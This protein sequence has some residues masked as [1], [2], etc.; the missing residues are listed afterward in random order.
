MKSHEYHIRLAELTTPLGSLLLTMVLFAVLMRLGVVLSLLPAPW[1]AFDVEH[2]ILTHQALASGKTSDA[3][4]VLIGDSSCLM[5]AA[6][7]TLEKEFAGKHHAIN[8]G[9]FMYVGLNGYTALLSRYTSAN[10]GRLQAVVLLLHPET[11]RTGTPVSH[12]LVFLSDVCAGADHSQAD[13]LRD[14]FSSLMG[15]DIFQGRCLSRV[16]LPLAKEFGQYY[17]FNLDLDR[18]MTAQRGS[19]V[20]PHQFK[21]ERGQGNAEYRIA[22]N[23]ESG[24]LA[25]KA[26]VPPDARLIIGLTPIPQSFASAGYDLR[27]RQL[28]AQWGN[29]IRA[30]VVLTNLPSAMADSWFASTTHLNAAGAGR[31]TEILAKCLEPHLATSA[32]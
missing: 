7:G 32:R 20:D 23:F 29:L 24:C 22:S 30:D 26:A 15:L 21:P 28:L 8:L 2:T 12:Y 18:F 5:D 16:P 27:W 19:A 6:G 13:S 1:P 4:V 3:D 11:L 14:Q 17:G 10:P 9:S 25:L 31:Y